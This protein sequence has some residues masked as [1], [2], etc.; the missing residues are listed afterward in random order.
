MAESQ[1]TELGHAVLLSGVPLRI[2]GGQ[3]S[4]PRFFRQHCDKKKCSDVII[5]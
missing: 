2:H 5:S 1:E 3:P 4:H